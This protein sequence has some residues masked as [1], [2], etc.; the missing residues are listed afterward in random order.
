LKGAATDLQAEAL[1]PGPIPASA[2]T[3]IVVADS[4]T[5]R[6]HYAVLARYG[7]APERFQWIVAPIFFDRDR[8]S[9]RIRSGGTIEETLWS[10]SLSWEDS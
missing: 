5:A 9:S 2:V 8:L 3:G 10:P 1:I 4:A 7:H 6:E